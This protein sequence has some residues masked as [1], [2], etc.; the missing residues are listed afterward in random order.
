MRSYDTNDKW[1]VKELA[2]LRAEPW[3]VAAVQRNPSYCSWGPYEDYMWKRGRDEGPD[4]MGRTEDNGWESRVLV[5]S[6]GDF[7]WSL[8]DLNICANFYFEINRDSEDCPTCSGTGNH[9]DAQWVT[10]SFYSHSSPFKKQTA[11]E[12]AAEAVMA[13]F[14]GGFRSHTHG[15]GNYPDDATLLK[16]GEVFAH[17]CK[18]MADRGSWGD[19]PFHP[20]EE[21]ALADAGRSRDALIG[22]DAINRGILCEARCKRLGLPYQCDVCK[23]YGYVFI[24]PAAHLSL[25]LWMLHP[26]KGASRGVHIKRVA[27]SDMPAVLAWL[28]EAA[29]QN[30]RLFAGVMA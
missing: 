3:M 11:R 1:D 13:G 17:F 18:E 21:R 25:V 15:F 29:E 2:R 5:D 4:A 19:G 27:E 7:G 8:D 26:R 23:G 16:Y 12:Q 30:A 24:E 20:D 22:H 14:G 10:E 9:P 6:W 28:R